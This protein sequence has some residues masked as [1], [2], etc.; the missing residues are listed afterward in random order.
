MIAPTVQFRD[1]YSLVEGLTDLVAHTGA[2]QRFMNVRL[3]R[4]GALRHCQ[5]M[6]VVGLD[7]RLQATVRNAE[8]ERTCSRWAPRAGSRPLQGFG[9][10]LAA[11]SRGRE[12]QS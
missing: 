9:I 3:T 1:R 4:Q 6:V 2:A 12:V 8:A 7:R 11:D 5:G 10:L